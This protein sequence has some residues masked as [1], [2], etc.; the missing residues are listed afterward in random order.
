M[1]YNRHMHKAILHAS[2]KYGGVQIPTSWDIQGATHLNLL[3]GHLQTRDLVGRYMLLCMDYLYLTLG[4]PAPVLSYSLLPYYPHHKTTLVPCNWLTSTW[5]Y[6]ST[7]HGTL[8]AQ[9]LRLHPQRVHDTTIMEHASHHFKGITL[10]RI[11]A[12]RLYLQVHHL[13]DIVNSQGTRISPEY[14]TY[15]QPPSRTTNLNWPYQHPPGLKAWRDWLTMLRR[16]FTTTT[17]HLKRPL[18]HWLHTPYTTQRWGTQINPDTLEIYHTTDYNTW[19]IYT[20]GRTRFSYT[21]SNTVLTSA[22]LS[23]L[24][25]TVRFTGNTMIPT[26]FHAYEEI[27]TFD[28]PHPPSFQSYIDSLPP[29]ERWTIGHISQ[30]AP[31]DHDTFLQ[32]LHTGHFCI[33]S[34]G[35]VRGHSVTYSGRLQ[36][37]SNLTLFLSTHSNT[38]FTST[39]RSEALGYLATLYLLRALTNYYQLHPPPSLQINHY[40]D[41]KGVIQRLAHQRVRSLRY[42]LLPHSDIIREI[43]SVQRSLPY[44]FHQ[45]HVKS[46]QHDDDSN[47]PLPISIQVNRDCDTAATKAHTCPICPPSCIPPIP[48]RNHYL[49]DSHPA[50]SPYPR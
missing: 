17:Y 20:P 11:N 37:L 30:L 16:C 39:L 12:C 42:H 6:L 22:P 46:H 19:R 36:H 26:P 50:A 35:S 32:A 15:Q 28:V 4:L 44:T 2:Y 31:T 5:H 1:G 29:H 13:S 18:G 21:S 25:I 43:R 23:C 8:T 14:T 34:D 49:P 10:L 48:Y 38:P 47:T 7:I 9:T 45:H 24:P 40:I 41:N 33:G 3:L 27:I